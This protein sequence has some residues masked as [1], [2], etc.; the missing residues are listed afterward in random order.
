MICVKGNGS[1]ANSSI[2]RQSWVQGVTPPSPVFV[3]LLLPRF[4]LKSAAETIIIY[5]K[6]LHELK[7]EP[8]V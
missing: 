1:G 6:H 8:S 2:G 4:S 5:Y 7:D 3:S